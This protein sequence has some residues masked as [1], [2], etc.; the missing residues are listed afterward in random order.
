MAGNQRGW[1]LRRLLRSAVALALLAAACAPTAQQTNPTPP[2]SFYV[3]FP[4]DSAELTPEAFAVLDQVAAEAQRIQ[5]TGVGI[6]GYSS[7]S[8]ASAHNLRLS[9]QRAGAVETALLSRG[10][11]RDIIVRN[12]QG[13]TQELAGSQLGGQRVEI[14]VSRE[15]RR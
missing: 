8:G 15:E 1:L 12:Y 14:V 7:A 2:R 3:F 13:A 9:E 6:V 10:V 5:A 4:T 11:A